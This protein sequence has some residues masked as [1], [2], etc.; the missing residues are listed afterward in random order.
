[1]GYEQILFAQDSN[2]DRNFTSFPLSNVNVKPYKVRDINVND[3]NHW[4]LSYVG[5]ESTVDNDVSY[6]SMKVPMFD[7]YGNPIGL[8]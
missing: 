4:S 8:K 6:I 2:D 3:P 1:M 5:S 7:I